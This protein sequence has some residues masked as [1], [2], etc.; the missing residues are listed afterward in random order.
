MKD[1]MVFSVAFAYRLFSKVQSPQTGV[2]EGGAALLIRWA[3][4]SCM[5]IC[6]SCHVYFSSET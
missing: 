3:A 5:H 2:T 4:H 6:P 1:M